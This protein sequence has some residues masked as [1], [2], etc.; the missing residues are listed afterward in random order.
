MDLIGD[1]ADELLTEFRDKF[2]ID[3][4]EF[5]F[6]RYFPGEVSPEMHLYYSKK[7]IKKYQNPII[8]VIYYLDAKFWGLFAPKVDYQIMIISDLIE[9]A[10]RGKWEEV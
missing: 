6:E 4:S 7:A 10:K 2:N 8:R 3:M 5:F 9:C 1:D